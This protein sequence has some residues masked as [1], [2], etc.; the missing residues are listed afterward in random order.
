MNKSVIMLMILASLAGLFQACKNDEQGA[1]QGEGVVSG[2]VVDGA[3]SAALG[4]VTISAQAVAASSQ[5]KV[6]DA[7]GTFRFSF[8]TD[9]SKAVTMVFQKSGYRDTSF[10]VTIE[11]GTVTTVT[12]QMTPTH[13]IS[14]EGGSGV[15]ATIAIIRSGDPQEV[16]VYGVGGVET[17]YLR[18]EV[19][20]S[21]GLPIDAAHAVTLN[22]SI[23]NGPGGGEYVSPVS[24]VTNAQGRATVAFN[25]GIRAGVA[26]VV[27]TTTVGGRTITSTP[28]RIV[29]RAG[30]P[31]QVHFTV[32]PDYH[33]FPA[34]FIVGLDMPISVIVG[35]KYSNP[36]EPSTAVYFRTVAGVIQATGLTNGS[37]MATVS[38]F[39]G[40]PF[41]LGVYGS[42]QYGDGYHYVIA[43]TIGEGA[44]T[45]MDSTLM[46]WSGRTE[47]S[48]IS[49]ST[50]NVPQLGS[51]TISFRV[52]DALGHPLAHG[53]Q[54]NVSG[55]ATP[56]QIFVYFGLNGSLTLDDVMFPGPG[57]TDF[58]FTVADGD[59]ANVLSTVNV[60]VTVAGPNGQAFA[61]VGGI[62]H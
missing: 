3:T 57:T 34:L 52:S 42:Q 6:T 32:A 21:V 47:I 27:A 5:Q 35:D 50:I 49:P 1:S 62:S 10:V 53:T 38:L 36:V 56:S 13:A 58:T 8:A 20:D 24:A 59:T 61:S 55:N 25:S 60:Q 48:G 16:S 45:V 26:Q 9:S 18:W 43:R 12:V 29:I 4:N 39:S 17:T 28:V 51:Q 46:L 40:N 30:L 44:V 2:T 7:T 41:P 14:S 11:P 37:G 33:N 23:P 15:A 54:I 19:H 31:D 22:F